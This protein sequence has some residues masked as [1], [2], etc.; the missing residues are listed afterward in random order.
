MKW[1]IPTRIDISSTLYRYLHHVFIKEEIK[2][3]LRRNN[4]IDGMFFFSYEEDGIIY[5]K[6]IDSKITEC[7]DGL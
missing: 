3:I 7:E 2:E 4:K 1:K 6:I 5:W